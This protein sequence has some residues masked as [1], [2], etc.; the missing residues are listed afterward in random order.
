MATEPVV[1]QG[2]PL[3]E[4]EG[5]EKVYHSRF[6]GS[7]F[8]FADGSEVMFN[9][10][11]EFTTKDLA[12]QKELDKVSDKAGSPVYSKGTGPVMTEAD[13]APARDIQSR[14]A[15]VVKQLK[16]DEARKTGG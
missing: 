10:K 16:A 4:G 7:R 12:Q 5:S 2:E 11:G 3:G 15:E 8:I 14:A 9:G 13:S 6:P 1:V